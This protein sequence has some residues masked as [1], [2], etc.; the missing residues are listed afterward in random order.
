MAPSG[1]R[2]NGR[3]GSRGPGE[4]HLRK[5][6][7][8]SKMIE[9]QCPRCKQYWYH[10][11]EEGGRVRLCSRCL[12]HLRYKGRQRGFIDLP[13]LLVGGMLLGIDLLLIA[14][15]AL[16]PN[17]FAKV[18]LVY[19]GLQLFGGMVALSWL[20][21]SKEEGRA[22]YLSWF[23]YDTNWKFGRWPLLIAISG[24]VCF[25]ASGAFLGFRNADE[26]TSVPT[27]KITNQERGKIR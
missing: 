25:L 6:G 18:M 21:F 24:M 3:C 5:I 1:V 20:G 17:P 23:T 13:F 27:E 4:S 22:A 7:R 9:I 12:D 8:D 11:D 10:N 16:R 14:V 26:I 19:G 15:T 2:I